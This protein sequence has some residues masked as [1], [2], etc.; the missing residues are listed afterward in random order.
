MDIKTDSENEDMR[1][2]SR[3]YGR[4]VII[5]LLAF[6]VVFA[7]VDAF[8]VYK[9]VKTGSGETRNSYKQ[10]LEYNKILD[11]ASR[12]QKMNLN[13]QARYSHGKIIF[14]LKDQTG[15]PISG[16]L[17]TAYM[18]RPVHEGM[19]FNVRLTYIKDGIYQVEPQFPAK[20]LWTAGLEAKWQDNSQTQ[21]YKTVIS[22]TL[23]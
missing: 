4:R 19:D 21:Q 16:A 6:F 20:G 1:K 13:A 9:A 8:F 17:V 15:K 10:G 18:R 22:L 5:I 23:E 3:E 2:L 14:S 7:S 12:Q 11:A